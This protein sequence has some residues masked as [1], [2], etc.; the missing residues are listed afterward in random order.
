MLSPRLDRALFSISLQ[1]IALRIPARKCNSFMQRLSGHILQRPKIKPIQP[2]SDQPS[3]TTRLL[4]LA[5][6]VSDLAL[7]G[8]PEELRQYVQQE[9]GVAVHHHVQL[10]Y[11]KFSA[12]QVL[13][14]LLPAGL[15]VP[16]AYEQV[17]HIAHMNLRDELLPYKSLIGEVC[18]PSRCPPGGQRRLGGA[19]VRPHFAPRPPSPSRVRAAKARTHCPPPLFSLLCVR[20]SPGHSGQE[21]PAADGGE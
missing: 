11:D 2:N 4:L 8:L 9:G 19:Y 3:G 15:E 21:H 18:P 14:K 7:T 17:G 20:L 12:E 5:E 6:G 1:L 16:S 10:G 13:R